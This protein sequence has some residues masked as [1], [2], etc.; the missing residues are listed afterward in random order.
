MIHLGG[1]GT[2][3]SLAVALMLVTLGCAG[4]GARGPGAKH[5][6]LKIAQPFPTRDALDKVA[7]T[8]LQPLPTQ[9]VATTAEWSFDTTP[10]DA[11]APVETRHAQAATKAGVHLTYAK[12]LRCVARE[13]ARFRLE[14]DAY[15]DER[16]KR[17]IVASCGL[18]TTQV[19]YAEQRGEAPPEISDEKLVEQFGYSNNFQVPALEKVSLN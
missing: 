17:F 16:L 13:L 2:L 12:E 7:Q 19:S 5:P 14:H 15:P 18:T 9:S 11:P 8:P 10:V 1:R 4:E 6:S 3:S